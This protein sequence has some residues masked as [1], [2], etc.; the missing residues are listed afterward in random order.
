M[1]PRVSKWVD[2]LERVTW[3]AIQASAG[4]TLVV[5]STGVDWREGLAFVGITTLT[6]VVKNVAGQNIGEDDTG[7][8]VPGGSAISP[9]PQS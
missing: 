7:A 9:P 8:I 1:N 5:L 2:F 3:T 4:A 6:S